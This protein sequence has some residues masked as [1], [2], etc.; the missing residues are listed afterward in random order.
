MS[1]QHTSGPLIYCPES[2]DIIRDDD[3]RPLVATINFENVSRQQADA[4]GYLFA[5]GPELVDALNRII[6]P[7]PGVKKL[8]A[9]VYGIA[10]PAIAKAEGRDQ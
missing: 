2:G 1:A 4:D 9:W 6:N 8:P 3:V 7:A 10:V 5:A